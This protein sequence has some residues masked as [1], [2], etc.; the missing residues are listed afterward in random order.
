MYETVYH[1]APAVV[2]PVFCDHD[3]NSEKSKSDGYG[4]RLIE[5]FEVD[6]TFSLT[7]LILIFVAYKLHLETLTSEKLFK[8]IHSVI[9]DPQ[10]RREAK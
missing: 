10:Y 8:S 9:H 1:G 6:L 7:Y 5:K 3:V 2:M 4:E